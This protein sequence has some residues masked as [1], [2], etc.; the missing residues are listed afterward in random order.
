MRTE[1]N[2]MQE[3]VLFAL[4][5]CMT[6]SDCSNTFGALMSHII[7]HVIRLARPGKLLESLTSHLWLSST[8]VSTRAGLFLGHVVF[9]AS[10][11]RLRLLQV[12]RRVSKIK[13]RIDSSYC[14]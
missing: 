5:F 4:C 12:R 3:V 6:W 8:D 9:E 7:R 1:S 11:C 2:C 13:I 10:C 14:A